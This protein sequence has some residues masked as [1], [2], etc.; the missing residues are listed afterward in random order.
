MNS[1]P[2]TNDRHADS[3]PALQGGVHRS[4]SNTPSPSARTPV[5]STNTQFSGGRP[6][7]HDTSASSSPAAASTRRRTAAEPPLRPPL[8]RLSGN[9]NVAP[10]PPQ[11]GPGAETSG[12]LRGGAQ[13]SRSA[14]PSQSGRG[15]GGLDLAAPWH[16]PVA[17]EQGEAGWL[18]ARMQISG[19]FAVRREEAGCA[20]SMAE[21][22]L[23]NITAALGALL[24][25]LP[26]R[27]G[28]FHDSMHGGIMHAVPNLAVSA[29][30]LFVSS[31]AG[32]FLLGHGINMPGALPFLASLDP[33][34]WVP[35]APEQACAWL[36][37]PA[38]R[39]VAGGQ[40]GRTRCS[41]PP[42][43]CPWILQLWPLGWGWAMG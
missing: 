13:A 4:G 34:S 39:Q 22:T 7:A 18:G 29:T 40:P 19:N 8:S 33:A 11:K 2:S 26:V 32:R 37:L 14:P 23:C 15:P 17:A 10:Q 38:G 35:F 16:L 6:G 3:L 36:E 21:L 42:A 5:T 20:Y 31:A 25:S 30:C 12:L 43:P 41:A 27:V 9:S 24:N 28:C 1:Q